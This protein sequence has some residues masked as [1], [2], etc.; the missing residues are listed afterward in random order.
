MW[1]G[2]WEEEEE[3]EEGEGCARNGLRSE[4]RG[5]EQGEERRICK[6]L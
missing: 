4:G 5:K 6:E 3:E 2:D 1:K